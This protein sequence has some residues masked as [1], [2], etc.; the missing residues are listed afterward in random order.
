LLVLSVIQGLAYNSH[1][2][3]PFLR[4]FAVNV[5]FLVAVPILI[6]AETRIDHE[7][8]TTVAHFFKSGLVKSTE[9]PSFEAVI[10][11]VLRLRDHVLPEIIML[12]VSVIPS[13][14]TRGMEPMTGHVPTWHSLSGDASSTLSYAGWWFGLVSVPIFR[15]LL[16]RWTWRILLWTYFLRQVSRIDL[17]FVP[18]HADLAAGLGFLAEAQRSFSAIVFAGGSVISAQVANAIIYEGDTLRGLKFVMIGYCVFAML[19]LTA[20]LLVV[21]PTLIKVRKRGLL[22]YGALEA[23]YGQ[24]FAAKWIKGKHRTGE[25]PLGSDDI[26]SLADMGNSFVFVRDMRIVPVDK[27]TFVVLAL[28]AALPLIPMLIFVTPTDELIRTLLKFLA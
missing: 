5:R 17:H 14:T 28:A 13:L 24:E 15:F 11:K 2:R 19:L 27:R 20:P 1:L 6:L 12:A 23:T 3:I 9:L 26:Q 21:M 8:R 22:E 4:D 7:L 18:T 16:L 10:K 25:T